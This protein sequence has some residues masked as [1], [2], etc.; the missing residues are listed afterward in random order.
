VGVQDEI[1]I[2]LNYTGLTKQGSRYSYNMQQA[3]GSS[4]FA[5]LAGGSFSC[6]VP[7]DR[8]LNPLKK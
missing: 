1:S 2:L 3:V 6:L 5:R 8:P 7:N 4:R